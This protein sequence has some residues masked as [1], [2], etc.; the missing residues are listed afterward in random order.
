MRPVSPVIP[1][2]EP[3]EI[4][5]GEGQKQYIPLPT[6]VD[7]SKEK[8]FWSRWEFSDEER[9]LISEG[10]TLMLQQLTFGNLFQPVSLQIVSKEE[11]DS[12]SQVHIP[13]GCAQ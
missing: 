1:G 6:I 13:G 4:N 11:I 3:F 5:V 9:R 7:D 2:Y 8:R 12:K 10:G